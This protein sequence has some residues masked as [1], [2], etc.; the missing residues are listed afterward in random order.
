MSQSLASVLFTDYRRR[1]LGLLLLHPEQAWHLRE[2]ARLTGTVPGTLTREL[3]KLTEAGVLQ[4]QSVGRQ[5][6]FS[7]N[8]ACPVYEE[9]ASLL[10]KTSGLVDVL[11]EAL[12]PMSAGIEV[13]FVFGSQA[14][15]KAK[16]GSDVDVMVIGEAGFAEV[17]QALYPAQATL[18]REINPKVYR[19][20]EWQKLVAAQGAFIRDVQAK[21]RLLVMGNEGI[22]MNGVMDDA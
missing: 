3:A 8:R 15:G 1:V 14:S 2:I 9:L 20:P 6:L 22:V 17:V 18:G 10:R 5:V 12:L 11:A 16:A 13:A 4:R 7:A 21:P 19:L